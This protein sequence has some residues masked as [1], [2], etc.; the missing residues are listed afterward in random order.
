MIIYLFYL[1]ISWGSFWFQVK[2]AHYS[3]LNNKA[4][5]GEDMWEQ[6][7]QNMNKGSQKAKGRHH[8]EQDFM[9]IPKY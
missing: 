2:E 4:V 5:C 9:E 1:F 7:Y 6:D 3:P 8:I